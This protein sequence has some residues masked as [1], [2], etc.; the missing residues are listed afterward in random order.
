MQKGE[1]MPPAKKNSGGKKPLNQRRKKVSETR[2]KAKK[3]VK[4]KT[5]FEIGEEL[6]ALGHNQYRTK[7]FGVRVLEHLFSNNYLARFLPYRTYRSAKDFN[8]S[9]FPEPNTGRLIVRTDPVR[10]NQTQTMEEWVSVPRLNISLERQPPSQSQREVRIW[11]D[12]VT[13]KHKGIRFIVHKV[14][15]LADYARSVQINVDIP[16]G[17][18]SIVSTK[19]RSDKFRD[20]DNVSRGRMTIDDS[21]RLRAI[22]REGVG[23]P[24]ELRA[25]TI[26]SLKKMVSFC[27]STGH[28]VF[29]TS[30]VTYKDERGREIPVPEFY[31]LI[32]GKRF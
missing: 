18:V 14:R 1:I 22:P 30:Y 10:R 29:E 17:E 4:K 3:P 28:K 32:F 6:P 7:I 15:P 31:D 19:A 25:T 11:M 12:R 5:I 16:R 26:P 9:H 20:E 27:Y 2:S 23:L 8:I 13:K 21:G 24:E